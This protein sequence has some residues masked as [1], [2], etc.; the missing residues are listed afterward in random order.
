MNSGILCNYCRIR[1]AFFLDKSRNLAACGRCALDVAG[2]LLTQSF[3][4]WKNLRSH[5][6][7]PILAAKPSTVTV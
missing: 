4:H 3:T 5:S 7:P 1:T 6:E 2:T